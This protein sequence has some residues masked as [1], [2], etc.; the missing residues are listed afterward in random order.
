M[1]NIKHTLGCLLGC[2]FLFLDCDLVLD[3]GLCLDVGLELDLL[4]S[5]GV[6]ALDLGLCSGLP[7]SI[8]FSNALSLE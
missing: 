2:F 8:K 1:N 5:T 7:W 3:L 4:F 6:L